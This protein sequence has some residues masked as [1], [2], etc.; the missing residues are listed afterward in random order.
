MADGKG[1]RSRAD[2]QTTFAWFN[3]EKVLKAAEERGGTVLFEAPDVSRI[4]RTQPPRLPRVRV[5]RGTAGKE[6][7]SLG[8]PF[9]PRLTDGAVSCW[10]CARE[11]GE[12]EVVRT[13]PGLSTCPGCGARLPFAE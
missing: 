2:L 10:S 5:K 4:V 9:G 13:G 3:G 8:L 7:P 6:P 1:A 11:L 12:T